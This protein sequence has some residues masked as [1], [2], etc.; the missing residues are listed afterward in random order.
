[1]G[2]YHGVHDIK[3]K[4]AIWLQSHAFAPAKPIEEFSIGD[5]IGYNWGYSSKVVGKVEVSPKYFELETETKE[6]ERYK[7]RVRKGTY[8]PYLMGW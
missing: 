4:K 5:F 6:G 2:Y 1:M 3:G 8:K 7:R